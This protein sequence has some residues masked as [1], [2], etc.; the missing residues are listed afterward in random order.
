MFK[1]FLKDHS[2]S[3]YS[4]SADIYPDV[5]NREYWKFFEGQNYVKNAEAALDYEWPIVKAT[6]YMEFKKSGDR[7][8]MERPYNQRRE[9]LVLFA[10][11]ELIEN[12]GRFL[13][14]IVN[15][16]C[17]ICEET[18]WSLS[19]HW[20]DEV[21]RNIHNIADPYIDLMVGET[22][23]HVAMIAKLLRD[24]LLEYCPEIL[25]RVEY[26]LEHR[27]KAP[28]LAH[29]EYWWM[30]YGKRIPNNW[31]PWIISNV[32]TVFLL[33]EKNIERTHA[34]FE[35][36]FIELQYYYDGLTD[37]GGCDEG[38]NYWGRA[39]AS[40]FECVYQMKQATGGKL[41][42]L[43]DEKCGKIGAYLKAVHVAKSYFVSVADA[44][45]G[46][47]I[48]FMP[49]N[50]MYANETN[51]KDLMDFCASVY[52]GRPASYNPYGLGTIRRIIY[53]REGVTALENYKADEF[54]HNKLEILPD[55]EL[56]GIRQGDLLIFAK[57]G[58]NDESH[59]HNDIG[60]FVFHEREIPVLADLGI[61]VYTKFTFSDQRYEMIDAVKGE[62]HT[63]PA[64]DGIAQQ[65]G[66]QYYADSFSANE[67]E[68]N[69]SFASAYPKELGLVRLERKLSFVENGMKCIDCFEREGKKNG[70][71]CEVFISVLP[72]EIVDNTAI[73]N[74]RYRVSANVGSVRGE[75][76]DFCDAGLEGAWKTKGFTRICIEAEDV[77]EIEIKL[78]II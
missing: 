7:G 16:L 74:G 5:H 57:G 1:K 49:I 70:K 55:V 66:K 20:V 31:N 11:A 58:H 56:A 24:P 27:V 37:D 47:L 4:F 39:G 46:S 32:M 12:K 77:C 30:G 15:G 29:R 21:P 10:L 59:N 67:D 75:Y 62:N 23:E 33:S 40:F 6:D 38:P 76:K 26:E 42:L 22:A 53:Q 18:T 41:D 72:V 25:D 19:A 43:G 35:K 73:I 28:Y 60:S 34:A 54:V 8:V 69:I 48:G 51:Q 61:G 65:Y 2:F 68:I 45:Y 17:A 44:H 71:L 14:Q 78:E 13:P 63:I 9:K 36:M 52:A 64:F 50:F 3:E